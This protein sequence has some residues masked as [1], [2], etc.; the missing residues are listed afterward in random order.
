[1]HPAKLIFVGGFLGA[2]KTTLIAEAARRLAGR[3]LRV[4]LITNDQAA[5]LVDTHNLRHQGLNVQEVA[6]G[7]FCCRFE[8]LIAA[9]DSL[10][11]RLQPDVLLGEPVGSCT[12]I[13]ATVLQP[14]KQLHPDRWREWRMKNVKCRMENV[15][16]RMENEKW[17]MENG[18]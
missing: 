1:M 6:G 5:G 11:G 4:G 15:E 17:R 14:L 9:A 7:C 10:A 8:D 18:E 12:D 16:C 13:S 2:G 3:G